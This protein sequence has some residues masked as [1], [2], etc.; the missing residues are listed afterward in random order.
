MGTI[1][2][3]YNGEIAHIRDAFL[4]SEKEYLTALATIPEFSEY[5]YNLSQYD[6]DILFNEATKLMHQIETGC[7]VNEEDLENA[8]LQLMAIFASIN[9]A[10]RVKILELLPDYTQEQSHGRSR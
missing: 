3:N 10:V 1:G 2:N 9:D 8:E 6:S 7:F 4:S 5:V